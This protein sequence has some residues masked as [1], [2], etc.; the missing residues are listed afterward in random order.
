MR[1]DVLNQTFKV[2]GGCLSLTTREP[3]MVDFAKKRIRKRIDA[4]PDALARAIRNR[5]HRP[6]SNTQC[7]ILNFVHYADYTY[8]DHYGQ[9]NVSADH[10]IGGDGDLLERLD[11]LIVEELWS[12]YYS[13]GNAWYE[14][15]SCDEVDGGDVGD[16][17]GGGGGGD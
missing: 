7:K 10:H 15:D 14:R 12:A 5:G 4:N 13:G 6:L 2:M 9:D 1:L 17:G 3:N 11:L 8:K 16:S